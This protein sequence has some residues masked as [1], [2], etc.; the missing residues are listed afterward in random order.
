MT[1]AF[2]G[3]YTVFW[4]IHCIC[5]PVCYMVTVKIYNYISNDSLELTFTFMMNR[6]TK[7]ITASHIN[8]TR[9]TYLNTYMHHA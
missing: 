1:T 8:I 7:N 2:F 9:Y 4:I 3:L 6:Q 5:L